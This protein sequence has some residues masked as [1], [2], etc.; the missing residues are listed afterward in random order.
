MIITLTDDQL[1]QLVPLL[2]QDRNIVAEIRLASAPG[3]QS[4]AHLFVRTISLK[5]ADKIRDTIRK[6]SE[7]D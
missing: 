3:Q 6:D 4:A 2:N 7:S 5:A 1:R